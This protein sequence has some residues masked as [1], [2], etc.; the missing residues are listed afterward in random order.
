MGLTGSPEYKVMINGKSTTKKSTPKQ[1]KSR[2]QTG[3]ST[4]ETTGSAGH[5]KFRRHQEFKH[6]GVS[7]AGQTGDKRQTSPNKVDLLFRLVGNSNESPI[8]INGIETLALIDSGSQ[9]TTLS[10]EFYNNMNPKPELYSMEEIGLKVKGAGGHTLT[11]LGAIVCTIEVP[12]LVDQPIEIAAL[13]LPTTDYSLTVPVIVGT[14]AI[15]RCR[16]RC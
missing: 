14:N 6:V 7:V 11:Y 2:K 5:T 1:S 15:S 12:F 8:E 9:I 3:K 4:G 10:E 16:Q 13:V